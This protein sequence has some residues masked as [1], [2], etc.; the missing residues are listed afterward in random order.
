MI[1]QYFLYLRVNAFSQSLSKSYFE[2]RKKRVVRCPGS[3]WE[4]ENGASS[5]PS[6]S[7]LGQLRM[8]MEIGE[9][10]TPSSAFSFPLSCPSLQFACCWNVEARPGKVIFVTWSGRR[11]GCSLTSASF[12]SWV[13]LSQVLTCSACGSRVVCYLSPCTSAERG[14]KQSLWSKGGWKRKPH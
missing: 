8:E 5:S 4:I 11:C 2:R 3:I 14:K 13:Q 12:A 1:L 7:A 10:G 9:A 6:T